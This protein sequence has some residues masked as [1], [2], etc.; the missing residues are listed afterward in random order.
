MT[1][2]IIFYYS[3]CCSRHK[4]F[5]CENNIYN[6]KYILV[7]QCW[8]K[9][10]SI[11]NEIVCTAP[12]ILFIKRLF[13][14]NTMFW[15]KVLCATQ[16]ILFEKWCAQKRLFYI[17]RSVVRGIKHWFNILHVLL[18]YTFFKIIIVKSNMHGTELSIKINQISFLI[19]WVVRITEHSID[20]RMC[21]TKI[22]YHK[23]MFK[24]CCVNGKE[25]SFEERKSG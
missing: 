22:F 5:Y 6:E 24:L 14:T 21:K 8:L 13:K 20:T 16:N 9:Q 4:T 1:A 11:S 18:K 23:I 25:H 15:W 19:E 17:M 7:K 12:I 10:R 2:K 3:N